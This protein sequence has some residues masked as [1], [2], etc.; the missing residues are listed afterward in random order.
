MCSKKTTTQFLSI[1][2]IVIENLEK[3]GAIR[4]HNCLFRS[5][6]EIAI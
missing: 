4:L 5:A 6:K 1:H 2:V 3:G